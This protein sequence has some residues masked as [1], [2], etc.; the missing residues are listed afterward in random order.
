MLCARCDE[1]I[2]P[3]ETPRPVDHHSPS[4]GG[5][6]VYVHDY[7]CKRAPRQTYPTRR[8]GQ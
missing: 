5:S 4:A 7:L 6:T 3:D 1:P 2:R 8:R